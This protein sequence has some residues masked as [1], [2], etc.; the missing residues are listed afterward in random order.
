LISL[1]LLGHALVEGTSHSR[2]IGLK[3]TAA[4]VVVY[5]LLS[6]YVLV[7]NF[8]D[9]FFAFERTEVFQG[10]L[11]EV[12]R[13]HEVSVKVGT[14]TDFE[15]WSSIFSGGVAHVCVVGDHLHV[16]QTVSQH[17]HAADRDDEIELCFDKR[18]D[19]VDWIVHAD[20]IARS[21]YTSASVGRYIKGPWQT[22]EL[23]AF[24]DSVGVWHDTAR[25]V[26]EQA[27][28]TSSFGI[29]AYGDRFKPDPLLTQRRLRIGSDVARR[30]ERFG[31]YSCLSTFDPSSIQYPDLGHGSDQL[32]VPV[33]PNCSIRAVIFLGPTMDKSFL[34]RMRSL[35]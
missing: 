10:V 6:V 2:T 1:A 11:V 16:R 22:K 34:L 28:N 26:Y 18:I 17:A 35:D 5:C 3:W 15:M 4:L 29:P 13:D 19:A 32:Y 24:F 31:C 27:R 12:V 33:C 7:K 9:Y 21:K 8:T 25:V 14:G 23:F 20:S 30:A